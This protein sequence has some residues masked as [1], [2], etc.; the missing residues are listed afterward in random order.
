MKTSITE[1]ISAWFKR[2]FSRPDAIALLLTLIV[3]ILLLELFGADVL[4]AIV[5]VI[6]AYLLM[7]LIAGLERLRCPKWLALGIVYVVFLGV[8]LAAL[9]ALVPFLWRQLSGLILYLPEALQHS[10]GWFK[11]FAAHYPNVLPSDPINWLVGYLQQE[12]SRMGQLLVK[13]SLASLSG[14]IEVIVY[15][16]L[17]PVLVFLCLTEK[18]RLTGMVSDYLPRERGLILLV[19][20]DINQQFLAYIRARVIEIIVVWA[21]STIALLCFSFHYA[22]LLGLLIG[23]SVL[24]PYVGAVA[25]ALPI[26]LLGLI[27]YGAGAEFIYLMVTYL[28]IIGLDAYLLTPFLFSGILAL[29]PVVTIVSILLFGGIWGF[30]GVFFAI[31]LALVIRTL[32]LSWPKAEV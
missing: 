18:D 2:R 12:V 24:V 17:V 6:L 23:L 16:V 26:I 13:W 14:L 21:V 11:E 15:L 19:W 31:P 22:Y 25:A 32:I 5:S 4:P 8:F 27:Q 9:F 7:P 20:S 3:A 10:Q 1:V 29:S 30:W 28:V